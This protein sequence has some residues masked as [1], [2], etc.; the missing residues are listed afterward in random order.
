MFAP[1]DCGHLR[2]FAPNYA[3]LQVFPHNKRL[4]YFLKRPAALA[5]FQFRVIAWFA[6]NIKIRFVGRGFLDAT[7][8]DFEPDAFVDV[9]EK[10]L[11]E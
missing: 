10:D 3:Y 7:E 2:L 8:G 9:I 11:G 1:S 6:S 5:G 4:F